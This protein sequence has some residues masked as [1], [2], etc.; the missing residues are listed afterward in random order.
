MSPQTERRLDFMWRTIA[1]AGTLFM[2]GVA[3]SG[4]VRLPAQLKDVR[5]TVDSFRIDQAGIHRTLNGL[6][7]T[8]RETLCLQLAEREHTD[9]RR[10]IHLDTVP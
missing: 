7:R 5:A 4:Y 8:V 3:F 10:C 2:G 6:E 1:I 9:W